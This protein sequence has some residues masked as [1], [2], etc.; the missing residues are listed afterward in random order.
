MKVEF[1]M[2]RF[3]AASPIHDAPFKEPVAR[4]VRYIDL[5][6]YCVHVLFGYSYARRKTR[7]PGI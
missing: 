1:D 7:Q 6:S 5:R 3:L 2:H 4:S